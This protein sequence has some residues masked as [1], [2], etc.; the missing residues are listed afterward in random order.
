MS[1]LQQHASAAVAAADGCAHGEFSRAFHTRATTDLGQALIATG[2]SYN[3]QRR[4][5]QSIQVA[6]LIGKIRDIRRAGAAALDLA[7][8][9]CGRI[10]GFWESDLNPWDWAAGS[11]LVLEAG[12]RWQCE[13]GPLGVEQTVAACPGVFDELARLTA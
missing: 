5:A 9:A 12:G 3:A 2:F 8:V 6:S 1:H 11:L 4:A 7:W 10:D 13:P